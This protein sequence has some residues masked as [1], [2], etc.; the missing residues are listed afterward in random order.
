M[1]Y[2]STLSCSGINL[3]SGI[4]VT[5]FVAEVAIFFLYV[6]SVNTPKDTNKT[7]ETY[8]SLYSDISYRNVL[9]F[10]RNVF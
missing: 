7:P 4:F 9:I 1:S 6:G 5:N 10:T 8:Q 2:L 3:L